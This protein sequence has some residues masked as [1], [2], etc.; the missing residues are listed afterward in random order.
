M[1]QPL[2]RIVQLPQQLDLKS[3]IDQTKQSAAFIHSLLVFL[4]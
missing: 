3:D 4:H 1:T 2:I